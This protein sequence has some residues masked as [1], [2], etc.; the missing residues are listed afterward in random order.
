MFRIMLASLRDMTETSLYE[1]LREKYQVG[2]HFIAAYL[3]GSF[4]TPHLDMP[5]FDQKLA[6][7][8]NQAIWTDYALSTNRR[9][10]DFAALL[11]PHFPPNA[12][13][14]LDVGSAYGGFLIG[15][16]ELG[17]D[18]KGV[19]CN[20]KFVQMSRANFQ[21][22]GRED[23]SIVGDILDPALLAQLGKVDIITCI[24]VIEHVKDVPAAMR[25]M[26][27]L[28]NP[29]GILVLLMPNRDSISNVMSDPHFGLFGLTLLKHDQARELYGFRF[30]QRDMYDVGEFFD[31][32]HY[33]SLLRGL[34]CE[35]QALPPAVP[36]TLRNTARLLP[37]F[38]R[39]WREFVSD[40][41]LALPLALRL[42]VALRALLHLGGFVV[43]LALA[44]PLRS[45]RPT[46]KVK[47]ADDAW[48]LVGKRKG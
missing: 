42:N 36:T 14:Y 8:P 28:L 9:G 38:L 35:A 6:S 19:E 20:E 24:D 26:V 10:R 44:V 29:G 45:R 13:R 33:L 15:F 37:R 7:T 39:R 18:V 31:Q 41:R 43:Q 40:G 2:D 4:G 34:G 27:G 30:S 12:R 48:F 17:L 1:M 21:D 11:R 46:L 16:M 22:Y 5:T 25:N 3:T 32:D 23:A 47:Y